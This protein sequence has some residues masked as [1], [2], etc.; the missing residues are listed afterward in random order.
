M[1]GKVMREA[2]VA[3]AIPVHFSRKYKEED[4]L[5]IKKEFELALKNKS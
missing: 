2:K 5:T 1:S 4:I 3:E